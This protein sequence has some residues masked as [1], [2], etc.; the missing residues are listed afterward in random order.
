MR[1]NQRRE[2]KERGDV[3]VIEETDTIDERETPHRL[4]EEILGKERQ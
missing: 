2:K 1:G 4:R 3:I